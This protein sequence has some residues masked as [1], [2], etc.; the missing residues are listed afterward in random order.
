ML[1]IE[2]L[3]GKATM[4][5]GRKGYHVTGLPPSFDKVNEEASRQARSLTISARRHD[6]P[7]TRIGSYGDERVWG[8]YDGNH[9]AVHVSPYIGQVTAEDYALAVDLFYAIARGEVRP[10]KAEGD[11]EGNP[12]SDASGTGP[13]RTEL[14]EC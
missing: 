1:F 8:S 11:R 6:L 3:Y 10:K 13:G 9:V 14:C 12:T 2:A 7:A 4:P 5:D